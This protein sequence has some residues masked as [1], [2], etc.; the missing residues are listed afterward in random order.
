[1]EKLDQEEKKVILVV[2]RDQRVTQDQ[3]G[4]KAIQDHRVRKVKR[5]QQAQ[6]VRGER[7]DRKG[8]KETPVPEV[9]EAKLD[10]RDLVGSQARRAAQQMWQMPAHYRKVLYS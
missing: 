1:M 5:E 3:K 8:R 6:L 2:H 10:L 4:K 9:N 7:R